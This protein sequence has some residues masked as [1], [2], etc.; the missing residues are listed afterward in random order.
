M[1]CAVLNFDF[2][3]E[4]NSFLFAEPLAFETARFVASDKIHLFARY[5]FTSG[6]HFRVSWASVTGQTVYS[7]V[8]KRE[9]A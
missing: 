5:C 4:M 9:E 1:R 8:G 6:S 7:E 2:F 3:A